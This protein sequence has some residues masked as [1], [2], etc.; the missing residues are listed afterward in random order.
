MLNVTNSPRTAA[1]VSMNWMS[2]Q[3]LSAGILILA[4][5]VV[6]FTSRTPA[7]LTQVTPDSASFFDVIEDYIPTE[8]PTLEDLGDGSFNAVNAAPLVAELNVAERK[9]AP[10]LNSLELK[11]EQIKNVM[12]LNTGYQEATAE[13]GQRVILAPGGWFQCQ[14]VTLDAYLTGSDNDKEWWIAHPMDVRQDVL[15][16]CSND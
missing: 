5:V 14:F 13:G 2:G 9:I 12:A 15:D 7:G 10:G 8:M 16:L 6:I 3:Y 4:A 11:Q 1:S